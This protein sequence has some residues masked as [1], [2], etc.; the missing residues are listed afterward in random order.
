ML[1]SSN[2][3][4]L[5]YFLSWYIILV[6][7]P[8]HWKQFWGIVLSISNW[9][10][11]SGSTIGFCRCQGINWYIV[12]IRALDGSLVPQDNHFHHRWADNLREC[13]SPDFPLVLLHKAEHVWFFSE[14]M[15]RLW[16][17]G[18]LQTPN[19]VWWSRFVVRG[20]RHD[21]NFWSSMTK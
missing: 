1:S 13:P 8:S 12:L 6:I 20:M 16:N 14:T 11:E 9:L 21:R 17:A 5:G 7:F 19:Y 18:T 10:C 2:I 4:L 15:T 3:S